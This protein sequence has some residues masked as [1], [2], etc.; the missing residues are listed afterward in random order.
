MDRAGGEHS[1]KFCNTP[2]T[3]LFLSCV[4]GAGLIHSWRLLTICMFLCTHQA[5]RKDRMEVTV[6]TQGDEGQW[7][8][9]ECSVL[10]TSMWA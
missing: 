2:D 10:V 1:H 8:G 6:G 7:P 9:P 5:D 4:Q 3:H